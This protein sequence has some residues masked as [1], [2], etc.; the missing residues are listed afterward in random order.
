MSNANDWRKRRASQVDDH[1]I[2]ELKDFIDEYKDADEIIVG[3]M[4]GK[5]ISFIVKFGDSYK[6][7]PILEVS[8]HLILSESVEED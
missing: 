3:V 7:I 6:M 5:D 8:K 4:K 1:V 2:T